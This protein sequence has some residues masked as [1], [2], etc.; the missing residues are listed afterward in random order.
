[1]TLNRLCV[2][3]GLRLRETRRYLKMTQV[4]FGQLLGVSG[5]CISEL[6]SGSTA[7]SKTLLLLMEYRLKINLKYLLNGKGQMFREPISSISPDGRKD[8]GG[9]EQPRFSREKEIRDKKTQEL[10]EFMQKN[11]KAR[12]FLGELIKRFVT[13]SLLIMEGG[14]CIMNMACSGNLG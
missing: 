3:R 6:E 9:R 4:E 1:M 13:Y 11:K 12:A 5:P 10:L 2:Q 8:R 14:L 7:P